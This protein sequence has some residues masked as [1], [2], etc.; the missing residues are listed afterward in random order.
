M[1]GEPSFDTHPDDYYIF[2]TFSNRASSI[3]QEIS[4]DEEQSHVTSK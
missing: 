2:F 1:Y 3:A 4:L